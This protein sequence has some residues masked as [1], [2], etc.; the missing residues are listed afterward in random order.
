MRRMLDN[1]EVNVT[2]SEDAAGDL[3]SVIR[4]ADVII[5][6]PGNPVTLS[7]DMV[8]PGAVVVDAEGLGALRMCA[9]F[10]NVI[11]VAR[12]VAEARQV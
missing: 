11:R 2:S 1:S 8:K 3:Q 12:K 4:D 10:D 6:V 5:I 9:L 7:A